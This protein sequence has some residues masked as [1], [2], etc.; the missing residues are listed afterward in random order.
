MVSKGWGNKHEDISL[1]LQHPHKS[2]ALR[3]LIVTSVLVDRDRQ[4]LG[5]HWPVILAKVLRS[6]FTEKPRIK[7]RWRSI[8]EKHLNIN[9]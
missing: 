3:C 9:L 8:W 5:L 7:L 6:K 4:I 2:K 1:H